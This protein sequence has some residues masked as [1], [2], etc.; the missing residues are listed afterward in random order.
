MGIL[1]DL[2]E[3]VVVMV[4]FSFFITSFAIRYERN[5]TSI[6]YS[7]DTAPDPRVVEDP[8]IG[9]GFGSSGCVEQIRVER[10]GPSG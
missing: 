9:L 4:G 5:G 1:T 10:F 6:T 7:A 3:T 8:D 2:P